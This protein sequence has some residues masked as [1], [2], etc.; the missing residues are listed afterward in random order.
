MVFTFLEAD[1]SI[2]LRLLGQDLR[3]QIFVVYFSQN[4]AHSSFTPWRALTIIAIDKAASMRS[5]MESVGSRGKTSYAVPKKEQLPWPQ[6][7]IVVQ[8]AT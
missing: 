3:P 5:L 2:A 1:L 8:L 4:T 6:M 7:R